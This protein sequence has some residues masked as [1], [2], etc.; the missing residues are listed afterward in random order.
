MSIQQNQCVCYLKLQDYDSLVAVC[1]RIINAINNLNKRVVD[2]A[3]HNRSH[4]TL[5]KEVTDKIL[6]R[7]LVRRANGY[8]NLGQV[9][10]AKA[11]LEKAIEIA[12]HD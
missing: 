1:I 10:N 12:P 5:P 6:V 11:D 2:F 4:S 3:K 8:V 9:Y 7:T